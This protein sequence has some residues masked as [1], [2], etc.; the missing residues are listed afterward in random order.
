MGIE[1]WRV[2]ENDQD[3][4]SPFQARIVEGLGARTRVVALFIEA[5]DAY[6]ACGQSQAPSEDWKAAMPGLNRAARREEARAQHRSRGRSP[7]D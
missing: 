2:V 3:G 7:Y 4:T 1:S 6:R 5:A